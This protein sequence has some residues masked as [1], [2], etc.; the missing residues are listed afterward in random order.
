MNWYVCKIIYRIICGD[1]DHTAQFDEQLRLI[2][3]NDLLHAFNKARSTG[4]NEEDSFLNFVNKPV[5]WK[6]VDVA[7][8]HP[9]NALVDGAEIYSKISE[10][11]DG[12]NYISFIQL[13]AAHLQES[14]TFQSPVLN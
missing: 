2:E 3:A 9:L 11:A 5:R 12:E 13:R 6:F 14:A 7:E 4:K 8:I 1:G 10:E